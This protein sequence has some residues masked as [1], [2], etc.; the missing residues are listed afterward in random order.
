MAEIVALK[1]LIEARAHYGHLAR[2]LNPKSR[3]YVY[4]NRNG[5]SII[6]L[7]K[8]VEHF[9]Q[10]SV[11][12]EQLVAQGGHVLFVGTKRQSSDLVKDEALRAQQY[13]MNHR[14]LG[15]TLTNFPTI[16]KSIHKL[17]QLE[18]MS[19]DGTY[20]KL[21]KKEALNMERLRL[22]LDV[23][24]AGIKDMPG[25]PSAVFITDVNKEKTALL[26]AKHLGIPIVAIVDTNV[27]PQYVDY[28]I[29]GNDDS[30]K[31]LN[32]FIHSIAN[33]IISGLE[34]RKAEQAKKAHEQGHDK[35]SK[36]GGSSP[37]KTKKSSSFRAKDG[38]TV[39][40]ETIAKGEQ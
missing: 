28:P 13:Y 36:K 25:R 40:V 18:K 17:K 10:A 34:K 1:E 24:L 33:A 4:G 14:W 35:S 15:G 27:D 7:Q 30:L 9:K 19:Q 5:I 39:K 12:L 21:T 6:D 38:Q 37:G 23:N 22:K 32:L 2:L 31:S 26:E 3:K 8:T 16:R 11:F 20:Q 29:P